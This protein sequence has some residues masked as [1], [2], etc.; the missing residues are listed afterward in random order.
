MGSQNF[1]ALILLPYHSVV[2]SGVPRGSKLG[3]PLFLIPYGFNSSGG[4]CQL[5]LFRNIVKKYFYLNRLFLLSKAE[6]QIFTRF[7]TEVILAT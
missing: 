7:A 6:S 4:Y 2:K 5:N 3:H 1:M